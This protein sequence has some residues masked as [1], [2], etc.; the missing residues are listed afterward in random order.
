MIRR[1]KII[2]G[3]AAL[4]ASGW[5]VPGLAQS[6]D[7]KYW[8]EVGG[9]LPDVSSR[10]KVSPAATPDAGTSIDLESDLNLNKHK[11]LPQISA[12]VRLGGGWSLLGEYYSLSRSG[13]TAVS[14]DLVFDDVVYPSGAQ[15]DS[16]FDSTIYRAVV[17]YSFVR[18]ENTQIGAAIGLHAT[19]FDLQL[20]GE[21]RIGEATVSG[22]QRRRDFLAPLPTL[23]VFA[24]QKIGQDVT[25][26]ARGDYLSLKIDDYKG[27]LFNGEAAVTWRFSK[28]VGIGAMYRYVNYR[29]DVDKDRWVGRLQYRFSGPALFLR[30][31]FP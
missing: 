3:M 5:A 6:I 15:V 13:S 27:R 23:G 26:S 22:E 7:D 19:K 28:N 24:A 2:V 11:T 31:G 30:V 12:G 9:Y 18:D 17:G 16:S 10:V 1:R 8:I 20:R 29:V 4:A 25:L 21:A 14:R